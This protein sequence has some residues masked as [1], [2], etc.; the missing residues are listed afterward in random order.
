MDPK[1][2]R[3]LPCSMA[4]FILKFNDL[5]LEENSLELLIF[6]PPGNLCHKEAASLTSQNGDKSIF[7]KLY[8]YY[9]GVFSQ[10]ITFILVL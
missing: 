7:V 1:L 4:Q 9:H 3:F 8:V 10:D 5:Y 6:L 2:Q